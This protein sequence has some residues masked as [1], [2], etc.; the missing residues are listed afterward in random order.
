MR[1]GRENA[2]DLQSLRLLKRAQCC[3]RASL[4]DAIHCTWVEV[5][6]LP[7][8]LHVLSTGIHGHFRSQ[9]ADDNVATLRG[10][11]QETRIVTL[12]AQPLTARDQKVQTNRK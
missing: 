5:R 3:N 6:Y 10:T 4:P 7:L 9:V 11:G 12:A 8:C 2:I 1:L